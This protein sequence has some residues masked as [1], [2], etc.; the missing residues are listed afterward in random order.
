MVQENVWHKA[1]SKACKRRLPATVQGMRLEIGQLDDAT[2]RDIPMRGTCVRRQLW[3]ALSDR[4]F[5]QF[6]ISTAEFEVPTKKGV[7]DS[8]CSSTRRIHCS[9][10]V[11]GLARF[12]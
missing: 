8:L 7:Q 11:E 6:R 9:A 12:P 1:A 2:M 10:S 4:T 5:T 3:P